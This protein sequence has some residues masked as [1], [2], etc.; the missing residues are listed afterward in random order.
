MYGQLCFP[1]CFSKTKEGRP[2]ESRVQCWW[3][4]HSEGSKKIESK[5][6]GDIYV[7]VKG[8]VDSSSKFC[9]VIFRLSMWIEILKIIWGKPQFN[10][11]SKNNEGG[12]GDNI[13]ADKQRKEWMVR[14]IVSKLCL[15]M[16]S[17]KE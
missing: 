3:V 7:W 8:W 13:E 15:I 16:F 14:M 11:T 10:E 5:I 2:Q 4:G 12:N 6:I 17:N 9:K 1:L